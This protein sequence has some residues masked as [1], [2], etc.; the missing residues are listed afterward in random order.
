MPRRAASSATPTADTNPTTPAAPTAADYE[1]LRQQLEDLRRHLNPA[2]TNGKLGCKPERYDGSRQPRAVENWVKSLDDYFELNPS[3]RTTERMTVL[4]AASYLTDSAKG[5]YI[6]YISRHGEFHTWLEM[7]Q[8]LLDTYNPVDPINTFR[9]N[10]LFGTKQRV[11]ESPDSYYRRFL[12]AANL[13]DT[14]LPETYVTYLFAHGLQS[15]YKK[16]VLADTEFS[17][18][19]KPLDSLVAKIKRG[20]PPPAET[21]TPARTISNPSGYQNLGKRITSDTQDS[22][23]TKRPRTSS[24][25]G[26]KATSAMDD[27]PLTEGQRKFIDQNIAKGGGIVISD[28]VQNK[29]AWV[30]EARQRN[31]CINCVGPG[32]LKADCPTT[33]HTTLNAIFPRC[34]SIDPETEPLNDWS[35]P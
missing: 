17:R 3:Q 23:P 11:G 16:Q 10:F 8:W 20:P 22:R 13:L 18:W 33:K 30:K 15:Y 9:Y 1:A 26:R 19:D 27:T 4:T 34:E 29:S 24:F 28:M 21:T 6:S 31:L 5:D 7:K 32:H 35:Q 14:P 2:S 12:D 25:G